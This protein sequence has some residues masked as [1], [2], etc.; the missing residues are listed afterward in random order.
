MT[1][2]EWLGCDDSLRMLDFVRHRPANRKEQLY[3]CACCRRIWHLMQDDRCRA[4]VEV[5]ERLADGAAD[6]AEREAA[7]EAV[8]QATWGLPVDRDRA[9]R[10]ARHAGN[11]ALAAVRCNVPV[12]DMAAKYAAAI[13]ADHAPAAKREAKAAHVALLRDIYGPLPFRPIVLDPS[14]LAWNHGTV[15]AIGRRVYVERAY[16]DLPI[17]AD[18]LED[19]GCTDPDILRHCRGGGPHVRGCWVV[20][21]VLGNA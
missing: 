18:A 10:V 13:A 2:A 8:R 7:D 21:L 12:A 19:A 14:W 20:D 1:E 11:A 16:H 17:L 15:P 9:A 3:A 5:A 6:V 4:A